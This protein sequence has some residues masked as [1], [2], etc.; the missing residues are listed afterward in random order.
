MFVL[1]K[2]IKFF[3]TIEISSFYR[4]AI[5]IY[6]TFQCFDAKTN[7]VLLLCVLLR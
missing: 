2:R 3:I 7:D 5:L 1:K 4:I 6:V